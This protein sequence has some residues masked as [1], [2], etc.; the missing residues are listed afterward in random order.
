MAE[1]KQFNLQRIYL[2]DAS[3]EVP[4][5]PA[6]FQAQW[7]PK[8]DVQVH[9]QVEPIEGKADH[10]EVVLQVT[11]TAT[12]AE[13]TAYIAE[14]KQAGIFSHQGLTEDELKPALGVHGPTALFPYTRETI[15]DL[16]MKAS[17]P[18]FVLQ[19]I[20]FEAIYQ[21]HVQQ[22]KDAQNEAAQQPKH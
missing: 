20:N 13:Q 9:T 17:F 22:V 7:K 8:V 15:S 14:V 6:V 4:H 19:P 11:I 3:L 1:N 18:Q 5:A 16:I 12:N 2:K 21:Q 10:F